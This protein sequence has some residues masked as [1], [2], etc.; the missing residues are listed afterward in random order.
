MQ[1]SSCLEAELEELGEGENDPDGEGDPD[2]EDDWLA[3]NLSGKTV[4]H[5]DPNI[6]R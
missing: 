4:C 2:G 6:I 1:M 5:P 3:A